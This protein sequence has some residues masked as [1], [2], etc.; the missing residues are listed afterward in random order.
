MEDQVLSSKFRRTVGS[1]FQSGSA[2][3]VRYLR[4]CLTATEH[5]YIVPGEAN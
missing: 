2:A 3:S 1:F 5:S 4:E